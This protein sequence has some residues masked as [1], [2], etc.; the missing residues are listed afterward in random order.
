MRRVRRLRIS[1]VFNVE[2]DS[3][4]LAVQ[5]T[6]VNLLLQYID[7]V[8]DFFVQVQLVVRS[9]GNSR[10]PT[11]QLVVFV[12]GPG[13]RHSCRGADADSLG[14]VTIVFLPLLYIDKVSTFIVQVQFLECTRGG[15]SRAPTIAPR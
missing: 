7:K 2:A 6:I 8:I 4:G 5:Q 3:H 15:D 14:P 10:D 1:P 11:V 12:L 13:R 9:C